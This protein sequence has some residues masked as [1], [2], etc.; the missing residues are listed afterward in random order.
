MGLSLH[1]QTPEGA[2]RA[3]E[4]LVRVKIE[5]D[6]TVPF[7]LNRF[8]LGFVGTSLEILDPNGKPFDIPP[9]APGP[10]PLRK[11]EKLSPWTDVDGDGVAVRYIGFL[12]YRMPAGVY[13]V[14][15]VA[16]PYVDGE[17]KPPVKS[18]WA[19]FQIAHIGALPEI[20]IPPWYKRFWWWCC[21]W[22]CGWERCTC[23]K[24]HVAE[25]EEKL[26]GTCYPWESRFKLTIDYRLCIALVDVNIYYHFYNVIGIDPDEWARQVKAKIECYWGGRFKLCSGSKSKCGDGYQIYF[27]VNMRDT[28]DLTW[29]HYDITVTAATP[30]GTPTLTNWPATDGDDATVHEFGHML[31]NCDEYGSVACGDCAGLAFSFIDN[32]NG[33]V[34]HRYGGEPEAKH[35]EQ[36]RLAAESCLQTPVTVKR[37]DEPCIT[38]EPVPI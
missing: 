13:Q 28:E 37:V 21:R 26:N 9:P 20:A 25:H 15:F 30:T 16:H 32:P 27:R 5:N 22:C 3:S 2:L 1:I 10:G 17:K 8:D 19:S 24:H 36:I 29:Q 33:N 18:E 31:G 14:R 6:G 35:Y 34:M 11:E 12:D 4:V 23:T 7:R 38:I